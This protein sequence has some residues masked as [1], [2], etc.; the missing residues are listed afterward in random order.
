[1]EHGILECRWNGKTFQGRLYFFLDA[2]ISYACVTDLKSACWSPSTRNFSP[3]FLFISFLLTGTEQVQKIAYSVI[4]SETKD[5][6]SLSGSSSREG[7]IMRWGPFVVQ[8]S[9]SSGRQ[10]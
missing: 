9:E 8:G 6:A 2:L 10:P 7:G 3:F 4:V 5:E 1:M